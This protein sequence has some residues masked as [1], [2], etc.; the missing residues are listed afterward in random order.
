MRLELKDRRFLFNLFL[1]ATGAALFVR[2]FIVEDYRIASNSMF[3]NLTSGEVVFV[4]KSAFNLR[5]PF[6]ALEIIKFSYPKR[7]Q[8]VAFT[9]PDRNSATYVKRV[10]A[11]AGDRLEVRAGDLYIN[12]QLSNYQEPS[13]PQRQLTQSKAVIKFEQ[14]SGNRHYL[15][16]Q[17]QEHI[18]NYG[19]VDI[20]AEH[21]FVMGD[22]RLESVD[23]R[24]WGPVPYSCL[25][26]LVLTS[27]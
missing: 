27:S 15:I 24:V 16:Q 14:I 2:V 21:F 7:S 10:V 23:S 1:V 6:S 4:S 5:F 9:L 13:K 12:G 19:P 18:Q 3:P 8:I 20:P 11:V 22:N 17:D 26:G 25:K